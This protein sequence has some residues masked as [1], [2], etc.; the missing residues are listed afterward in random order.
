[1]TL[2]GWIAVL[3]R[4]TFAAAIKSTSRSRTMFLGAAKMTR[5]SGQLSRTITNIAPSSSAPFSGHYQVS[6][7]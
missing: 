4:K 5:A 1:M 3:V 2:K 7:K 6:Y